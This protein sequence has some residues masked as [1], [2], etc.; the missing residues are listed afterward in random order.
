[1]RRCSG[2]VAIAGLAL[3]GA[4]QADTLQDQVLAAARA[5]PRDGYAFRRTLS[6]ERTGS[7]RKVYVE[8]YDPR[9][10]PAARWTLVSVDGRAPTAKETAQSAKVKRGPTPSYAEIADWFGGAATRSDTAPGYVTYRFAR[11]PAGGLKIGSHDASADTQGEAL[12]NVKGRTPYVE[13]VR[14]MSTKGFRMMLVASVDGMTLSG[15]YTALGDGRIVPA[16]SAAV[17]TGSVVGK[18]GQVRTTT[19]YADFQ[20]VR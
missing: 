7:A 10:P 6:I 3:A 17:I 18:S 1:M 5:T 13:R 12:V 4:A 16:E 8:R 11:L 20:P 19:V 14:L 9:Q 2:I 15:R